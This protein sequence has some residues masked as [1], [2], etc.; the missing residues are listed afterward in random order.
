MNELQVAM[1]DLWIMSWLEWAL[2]LKH[3]FCLE[4]NLRHLFARWIEV[5]ESKTLHLLIIRVMPT[6]SFHDKQVCFLWSCLSNCH[7]CY[8]CTASIILA[9]YVCFSVDAPIASRSLSVSA[10]S[11]DFI[12]LWGCLR[13]ESMH[14]YMCVYAWKRLCVHRQGFA[15]KSLCMHIFVCTCKL[16]EKC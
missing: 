10:I 9:F 12:P 1:S 7:L 3:I 5:T 15:S 13:H 11:N 8:R 6:V 2:I 4:D 14:R 16:T